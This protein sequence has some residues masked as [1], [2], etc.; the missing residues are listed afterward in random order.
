M[1]NAE[2]AKWRGLRSVFATTIRTRLL[3]GIIAADPFQEAK[4]FDRRSRRASAMRRRELLVR[5]L[6]EHAVTHRDHPLR[7]ARHAT[8]VGDDHEGDAVLRV[9]LAEE[10]DHFLAG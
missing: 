10:V 5:R 6:H 8:L 1:P 3:P 7:D 2:S 4:R 9:E